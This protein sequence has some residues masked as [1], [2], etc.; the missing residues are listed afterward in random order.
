MSVPVTLLI[1]DLSRGVASDISRSLI[2]TK[3]DG[4]WHTGTL[5][6]WDGV[7]GVEYWFGPGWF[8]F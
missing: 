4:I 8:L 1:Y 3:V 6:R 5:V 7:N 2:G